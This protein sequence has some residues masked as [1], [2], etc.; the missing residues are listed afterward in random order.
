MPVY[1]VLVFCLI[2]GVP[3]HCQEITPNITDDF[4]MAGISA[5]AQMGERIGAEYVEAHPAWRLARV[6]CRIGVAPREQGI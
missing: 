4:L 2:G 1:L 6:K 3:E 5:C